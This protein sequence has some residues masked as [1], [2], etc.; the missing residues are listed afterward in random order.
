MGQ[1][2]L[3]LPDSLL[4]Q[5]RKLAEQDSVSMNQFIL[6]AVAE[7]ASAVATEDYFRERAARAD[8]N[9]ARQTLKKIE[10]LDHAAL[11]EDQ[12]AEQGSSRK[13]GGARKS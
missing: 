5:V 12:P 1:Y 10:R 13:R 11:P 2:A 8:F 7:K 9:N 6:S 4:K 3:R